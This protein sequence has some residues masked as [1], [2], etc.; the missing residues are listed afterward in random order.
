MIFRSGRRRQCVNTWLRK[1]EKV[2]WTFAVVEQVS[3]ANWQ[4][5]D[6]KDREKNLKLDFVHV[7]SE[8]LEIFALE[9]VYFHRKGFLTPSC[10]NKS[11]SSA[12]GRTLERK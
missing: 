8:C 9:G 1:H 2:Q 12:N 10:G 5:A 11:T 6:A 3:E 4:E 7:W